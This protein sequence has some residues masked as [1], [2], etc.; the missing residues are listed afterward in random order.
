MKIKNTF[1]LREI[2]GNRVVLPMGAPSDAFS[3]MMTLNET[4]A[5]LWKLLEKEISMEDL[6][7]AMLAEYNVDSMQA[8]KDVDEFL[9]TLRKAG[10]LEE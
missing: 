1:V 7:N 5:F 4:G 2:A 9:D 6:V 8:Q 10:V 3:G